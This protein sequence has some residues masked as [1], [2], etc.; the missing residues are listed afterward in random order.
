MGWRTT[1]NG[2][3]ATTS[4]PAPRAS[5]SPPGPAAPKTGCCNERAGR[6]TAGSV[7]LPLLRGHR[8]AAGGTGRRLVAVRQL[9]PGVPAEVH[10]R[11]GRGAEIVMNPVLLAVAHGSRDPAVFECVLSTTGR[12]SALLG[13]ARV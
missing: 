13:G 3:C 4:P 5:S 10:R 11:G 12:A 9:C 6:R 2:C 7:L 1:W 8:P